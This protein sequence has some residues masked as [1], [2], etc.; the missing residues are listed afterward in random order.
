MHWRAIARAHT[1]SMLT[2]CF[3]CILLCRVREIV[4][5]V[6]ADH[7]KAVTAMCVA[8]DHSF[9]V[10]GAEDGVLKVWDAARWGDRDASDTSPEAKSSYPALVGRIRALVPCEGSTSVAAA[11]GG[12]RGQVHV[13]RV[14]VQPPAVPEQCSQGLVATG[15]SEVGCTWPRT[16][17]I[18]TLDYAAEK[19]V[20]ALA[21][22]SREG[23]SGGGGVITA[24]VR[25]TGGW[26]PCV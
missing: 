17:T 22:S 4:L 5:S 18:R 20:M 16:T 23:G 10:S 19:R 3:L 9:F 15:E 7:K 21:H 14:D 13:V 12:R 26:H 8:H 2:K 24:C 6:Q 11:C 25:D 1:H